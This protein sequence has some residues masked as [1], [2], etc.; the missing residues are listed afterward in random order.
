MVSAWRQ[1]VPDE[2]SR[3]LGEMKRYLEFYTLKFQLNISTHFQVLKTIFTKAIFKNYYKASAK[4]NCQLLELYLSFKGLAK[5][6]FKNFFSRIAD[7]L[8]DIMQ[9][10][11]KLFIN[12][13]NIFNIKVWVLI[14]LCFV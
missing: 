9:R 3:N 4:L 6:T 11:F 14:A 2:V 12:F 8:A 10:A 13:I 1:R 5:I 7:Y